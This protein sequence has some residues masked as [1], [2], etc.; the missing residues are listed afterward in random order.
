M[1]KKIKIA[2]TTADPSVFK[3]GEEELNIYN[4]E[5]MREVN[6]TVR[7]AVAQA[8]NERGEYQTVE[9][10]EKGM[11]GELRDFQHDPALCYR[12]GRYAGVLEG[13]TAHSVATNEDSSA[14]S[15]QEAAKWMILGGGG[16]IASVTS[17][18]DQTRI[19]LQDAA[20]TKTQT[21]P[22]AR[23]IVDNFQRYTIGRGIK[24]KIPSEKVQSKINRFWAKNHMNSRQKLF[25]WDAYVRGELPLAYFISPSGGVRV[26]STP[27]KE[28]VQI[29]TDPDDVAMPLSYLRQWRDPR[30]HEDHQQIFADVNYFQNIEDEDFLVPYSQFHSSLSP[31]RLMQFIKYSCGEGETRGRVPMAPVLRW[32]RLHEE[33]GI[34]RAV[35]NH[36]RSK[37]LFKKIISGNTSEATTRYL[38]SP[39]ASVTLVETEDVQW[40]IMSAK[41]EA[42]SAKD[43]G[44]LLLYFIGAGVTVPLHI[45]DQNT[46][47]AVY[48]SIRKS[49]SPFAQAILD[50]Q[51]FWDNNFKVM[52]RI[53]I[54]AAMDAGTLPPKVKI[55][56]FL[57]EGEKGYQPWMDEET[58]SFRIYEAVRNG[59]TPDEVLDELSTDIQKAQTP[60]MVA[61]DEIP[62]NNIF[63]D[64]IIQDPLEQAQVALVH[65][66][67]GVASTRSLAAKAGYNFDM[68]M[69]LKHV[70]DQE[71]KALGIDIIPPTKSGRPVDGNPNSPKDQGALAKSGTTKKDRSPGT[72]RP[73]KPSR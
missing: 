19:M 45:L 27:P 10:M 38:P 24:I 70:E 35:L 56:R 58:F 61:T 30:T 15:L 36:E 11:L 51:D 41:I 16:G 44:L 55:R 14:R 53:V 60:K 20:F 37:V 33:F 46:S 28:I 50:N 23:S 65:Q 72:T 6:E 13:M 68:E 66:E 31:T 5:Q 22:H 21:S 63:P 2:A 1:A 8:V 34:D 9:D 40:E 26:R 39:P 64:M 67:L 52:E 29:E 62:I 18:D 69:F 57:Q 59:K 17:Q 12:L 48:A 32:I 3:F 71:A 73:R 42:A 25:V 49:D 43:D 7:L 54:R 47:Q 4:Q